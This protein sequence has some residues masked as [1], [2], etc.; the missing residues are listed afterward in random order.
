M[1]YDGAIRASDSDR[2]GVVEILREAYTEGR[3]DLGEFDERTTAA[4]AAKTWAQLR[5]LTRDLPVG[6]SLGAG[7][8]VRR[9][10]AALTPAGSAVRP[11]RGPAFIPLVPFVLFWF[12]LAGA[13][14]GGGGLVVPAV[15]L[16]FVWLRLGMRHLHSRNQPPSGSPPRT[17]GGPA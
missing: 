7:L 1:G 13:A 8:P 15:I 10:A 17:G 6:A 3:L 9:P 16:L 5:E 14:R 12:V 4:Y 11:S 2:E